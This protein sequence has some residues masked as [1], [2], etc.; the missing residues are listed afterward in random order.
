MPNAYP[1][2]GETAYGCGVPSGLAR[3]EDV[4]DT[5]DV[6]ACPTG[7]AVTTASGHVIMVNETGV[8][9]GLGVNKSV[10][11]GVGF[12]AL[13]DGVAVGAGTLNTAVQFAN[14]PVFTPES[15]AST[16]VWLFPMVMLL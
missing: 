8:G 2:I 15:L 9:A 13:E 5:G 14:V 12:C 16:P 7:T 3:G 11:A 10:G 6:V 4:P 1:R